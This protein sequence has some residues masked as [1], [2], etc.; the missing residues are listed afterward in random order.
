MAD[1][2]RHGIGEKSPSDKRMAVSERFVGQFTKTRIIAKDSF[3]KEREFEVLAILGAPADKVPSFGAFYG[4]YVKD[5]NTYLQGG[6]VK[7]GSV[8]KGIED[9]KILEGKRVP[10]SL[11]GKILWLEAVVDGIT[12]DKVLLPGLTLV[13]AKCSVQSTSG[14]KV[15]DDTL[16]TSSSP[17]GKKVFLEIGRWVESGFLPSRQGHIQISHCPGSYTITR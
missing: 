9:I 2:L 8:S 17:S 10:S 3:G 12:Q 6:G 7:A 13:S 1:R 5:G 14:E 4:I 15:P 16:P 11:V